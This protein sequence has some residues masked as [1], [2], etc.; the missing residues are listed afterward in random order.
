MGL[1]VRDNFDL[2]IR[3]L[4]A[5]IRQVGPKAIKHGIEEMRKEGETISD[6]ARDYA[7]IQDGKLWEAIKSEDAD[8]GRDD[9]GRRQ[10]VSVSV[11]VDGSMPGSPS[12]TGEDRL[13]G[14]Y[15]ML[16]HEE[17]GP[18]GSGRF[19][20]G[21]LTALDSPPRGGKFLERAVKERASAFYQRM[22]ERFRR[23]F[24]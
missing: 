21:P 3:E 5:K 23:F 6:L 7:P 8:G 16:M 11:Y 2:Q 24:K 13:V 9:L 1:D 18:Y 14:D 20:P 4:E 22:T 10:R 12:W 15:A 17:L 19:Q